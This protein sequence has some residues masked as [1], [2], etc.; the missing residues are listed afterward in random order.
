M[1]LAKAQS[2]EELREE[3]LR[4]QA[5]STLTQELIDKAASEPQ[6]TPLT[7]DPMVML[8]PKC[9]TDQAPDFYE[10]GK[11]ESSKKLPGFE[12]CKPSSSPLGQRAAATPVGRAA[13][14]QV[15]QSQVGLRAIARKASMVE[16]PSF[17]QNRAKLARQHTKLLAREETSRLAGKPTM[18][19]KELREKLRP[20]FAKFDEDGSGTVST[21]EM[22]KIVKQLK[23]Q[24]TPKQLAAMMKEADPD[25]SGEIDFEEFVA[26]LKV[27]MEK[28]GQLVSVMTE[29]SSFFSFL[30]PMNWW[31]PGSDVV[32]KI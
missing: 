1:E 13:Q 12:A 2:D 15:H 8:P 18:S 21:A 32:V 29:A 6:A 31:K 9:A 11:L 17:S 23:L 20:I 26:V 19:E 22:N 16:E 28:G 30:N 14:S 7:T 5:R 3:R 25:G 27:Q 24:M 10:T 4:L